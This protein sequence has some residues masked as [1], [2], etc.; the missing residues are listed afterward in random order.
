LCD[1]RDRCR[2]TSIPQP[3]SAATFP[4]SALVEDV[5]VA[6]DVHSVWDARPVTGPDDER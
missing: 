5:L 2:R 4:P 1:P 6:P 3:R